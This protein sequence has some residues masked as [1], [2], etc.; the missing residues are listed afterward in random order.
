MACPCLSLP[1]VLATKGGLEA[2]N[3]VMTSDVAFEFSFGDNTSAATTGVQWVKARTTY[4]RCH[5]CVRQAKRLHDA[6]SSLS[7]ESQTKWK[8]AT[9]AE[10]DAFKERNKDALAPDLRAVLQLLVEEAFVSFY[11]SLIFI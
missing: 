10:R 4:W 7:S 5:P 3:S 6:V 9:K 1:P 8:T 11:C 2:T